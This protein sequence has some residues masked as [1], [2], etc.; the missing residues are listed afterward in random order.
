MPRQKHQKSR[1]CQIQRLSERRLLA[2][3]LPLEGSPT[4]SLLA[5]VRVGDPVFFSRATPSAAITGAELIAP[6]GGTRTLVDNNDGFRIEVVPGRNLRNQTGA[7][8]AVKRA[9]AQWEAMLNDPITLSIQIDLQFRNTTRLPNE[10][11]PTETLGVANPSVTE[12]TYAEVRQAMQNDGLVEQDDSILR[13]LPSPE[14]IE[15]AYPGSIRYEEKI[16]LTKA[17]LKALGL[18]NE[19]FDDELGVVDGKILLNPEAD[20]PNDPHRFDYDKSDGISEGKYDFESLVVHEIGHV[21]GFISSVDQIDQ[22]VQS[23]VSDTAIAPST[24]D[25]F[26]FR[27]LPGPNNPRTPAAF[28][29]SRRELRPSTPAIIDFVMSDGWSTLANEYPVE[30][31]EATGQIEPLVTFGYQA[32]HWQNADLF[33]SSIG[34]MAPTLPLQTASPISN[35][36]LRLF[37][38]IGYDILPPGEPVDAPILSDDAIPPSNQR[39]VAIDVLANDKNNTRPLDLSSLRIV[40]PPAGGS[41]QIDP[42][43]GFIVFSAEPGF[44]G[45]DTFAYSVADDRGIYGVPAL[46]SLQIIGASIDDAPIA[47]DDFVLARQ[48]QSVFF[49][50]LTNDRDNDSTLSFSRLLVTVTPS[51]GTVRSENNQLV[52]TPRS[53]FSGDDSLTYTITDNDG[54]ASSAVVRITVGAPLQPEV[55]PGIPITLMQRSDISGDNRV[56]AMDA[57]MIINF[58]SR[59]SEVSNIIEPPDQTH[60]VN[61]DGHVTAL[62]A[63]TVINLLAQGS[64]RNQI[65]TAKADDTDIE[66]RFFNDTKVTTLF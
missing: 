36:D 33:G 23:G 41:V 7:M 49:N 29:K 45:E 14:S 42:A 26:R 57:L 43:S 17:N 55:I 22:A 12:L 18:H 11:L 6:E 9:A 24:L 15:F 64:T 30:L 20:R 19:S 54:N 62:D 35:V 34:V 1:I 25:L 38:L 31:G 37:D 52:Y 40:E 27:S 66:P 3:D 50:P 16:N 28:S 56:T 32:S 53:G 61:G 44:E 13:S 47:T 2:S 10:D 48:N 39:T 63:L 59:H 8:A 60:D 65:T 51:N 46:V 21:L 5:E 4:D 58:I